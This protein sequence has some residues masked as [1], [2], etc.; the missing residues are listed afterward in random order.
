MKWYGSLNNRIDEKRNSE[1]PKVGMGVTEYLWSDRHAYEITEVIDSK[2]FKMKR[3]D[4]KNVGKGFGD[5]NWEL[6]LD[7][8][9]PEYEMV[10]RCGSWYNVI[11]YTK[12]SIERCEREDGYVLLDEKIYNTAKEKGVAY[13]YNK[14]NIVIGVAD[15]Y[16]DFEF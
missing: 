11:K 5:N 6:T 2:H 10:F 1:E 7:E 8:N 3:Y 15:E 9:A 12:E 4:A 16:Y 13:K 14:M